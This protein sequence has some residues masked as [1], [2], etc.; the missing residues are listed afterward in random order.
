MR[1]LLVSLCCAHALICWSEEIDSARVA[2]AGL[3]VLT[4]VTLNGERPSYKEAV[5]NSSDYLGSSI[6]DATKVKGRVTISIKG[7]TVFD[8]GE[9]IED[10]SGMTIKVRGNTSAVGARKL[11]YKI[12]LVKKGDMLCRGNDSIY[13]DKNWLLIKDENINNKIGYKVNELI[14]MQWTPSYRYV[15]VMMNGSYEGLYMLIESVNRNSRC[16]LDVSETGYIAEFDPYFWNEDLYVASTLTHLKWLKMHYTF[17][18]PDNE[19]FTGEKLSYF[20]STVRNAENSLLDGTYSN[21]ID[22]A[23]FAR[24]ML[25]HDILGNGDGAGSNIYFTKYDNTKNSKIK[26]ANLWDLDCIM[27]N[28]D[29]WD[30][31]HNLGVFYFHYLFEGEN[32]DFKKTYKAIWREESSYIFDSMQEYLEDYAQSDEATAMDASIELN[33]LRWNSNYK[34]IR[35]RVDKAK[36]WFTERQEWLSAAISGIYTDISKPAI[37]E[38]KPVYYNL[39]G[40]KVSVPAKGIYIERSGRQKSRIVIIH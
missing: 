18:Y 28:R 5:K 13:K 19:D 37:E 9:Y 24:W 2:D 16:R 23:S 7:E 11:P 38:E 27:A 8:S 39:K 32:Q 1:K 4:I 35:Y 25:A 12:K 14:G 10:V 31:I 20:K 34:N 26:M 15:N 6:A 21:Y 36:Q 17:K 29:S 3:P 22:V 30:E 33:N 40:Q